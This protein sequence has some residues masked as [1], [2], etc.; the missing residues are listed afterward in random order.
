[1]NGHSQASNFRR[2]LGT[3]EEIFSREE[4][5]DLVE[6][7]ALYVHYHTVSTF[8]ITDRSYLAVAWVVF[9]TLSLVAPERLS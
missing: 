7:G 8:R 5:E 1:M 9:S 3:E 6:R 2:E 4:F